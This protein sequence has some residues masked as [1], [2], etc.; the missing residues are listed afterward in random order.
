MIITM[1][2]AFVGV[3]QLFKQ[4][5]GLPSRTPEVAK[6]LRNVAKA[7]ELLKKPYQENAMLKAFRSHA[8][9]NAKA[10]K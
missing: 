1:A 4:S 2:I 3:T 5:L 9:G 6:V 10:S 7:E 8:V